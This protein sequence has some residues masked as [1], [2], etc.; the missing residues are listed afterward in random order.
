MGRKPKKGVDYF[1]HD[2]DAST[3]PTLFTIQ[4]QFGNDG[5][6]FWFKLLEFLGQREN[7]SF[8]CN[9][10]S[11]WLFFVAKAKVS[12]ET[13]NQI[14]DTLASI[15]AIDAELWKNRIVWSQN[16]VERVEEVYR[17]RGIIPPTKPVIG[18]ENP[19][20]VEETVDELQDVV[21]NT[22]TEVET[23]QGVT[24]ETPSVETKPKRKGKKT[25]EEKEAEKTKYADY[26][27][28]K[29][30]EYDSLIATI[31]KEA[32][33]KAIAILNSYKGSKGKT[34]KNDYMA[35]HSWVIDKIKKDFPNLIKKDQSTEQGDSNSNPFASYLSGGGWNV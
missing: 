19:H 16:F 34:Y 20:I 2:C 7:L 6:A 30:S 3:K 28:M 21:S 31:G 32:A 23:Q 24:T 5:Y 12:E 35:I 27:R 14:L 26:V 10:K 17:K 29:P 1:S 9:V 33:D 8:D 11:E 4:S 22:E 13:A 18:E 25:D 15:D